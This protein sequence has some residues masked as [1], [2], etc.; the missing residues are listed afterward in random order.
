[1]LTLVSRELRFGPH[2]GAGQSPAHAEGSL[3]VKEAGAVPP[4]SQQSPCSASVWPASIGTWSMLVSPLARSPYRITASL[5]LC[6]VHLSI[7]PLI[8]ECQVH[9]QTLS[10]GGDGASAA[11]QLWPP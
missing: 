8:A 5:K 6:P 10:V 7:C 9:S 1:M 2:V 3:W 4:G 11:V